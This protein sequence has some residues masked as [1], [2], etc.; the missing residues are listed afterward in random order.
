MEMRRSD[1]GAGG[2][3]QGRMAFDDEADAL[4]GVGEP[5]NMLENAQTRDLS[6]TGS[7][8][9]EADALLGAA[10]PEHESMP[11]NAHS[12][13]I[14]A[15]SD[16]KARAVAPSELEKLVCMGFERDAAAAA[17]VQTGDNLEHAVAL[18]TGS[19]EGTGGG[20]AGG[21]DGAFDDD[22]LAKAVYLGEL[23]QQRQHL[24]QQLQDKHRQIQE[25]NQPTAYGS[26]FD[27]GALAQHSTASSSRG[28]EGFGNIGSSWSSK[29]ASKA[30]AVGQKI[31]L[32]AFNS[33][34]SSI[35]GMMDKKLTQAADKFDK[36]A[37]R[38]ADKAAAGVQKASLNFSSNV[39]SKASAW[40]S[41]FSR[42]V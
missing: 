35:F 22:A 39:S 9:A 7:G 8:R 5:V 32:G 19:A 25:Q 11:A 33:T 3:A 10:E 4:L 2:P 6:A 26:P 15:S 24:E 36:T 34:T 23:Q 27:F 38:L 12:I 31:D 1:R 37:D 16:L 14:A 18:L 28:G 29:F 13:D 30:A 17:L 21:A 40:K 41:S 42:K 20:V